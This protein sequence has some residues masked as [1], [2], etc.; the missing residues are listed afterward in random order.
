[1]VKLKNLFLALT[2]MLTFHQKALGFFCGCI[3][4]D[5]QDFRVFVAPQIAR[6]QLKIDHM[7]IYRGVMKGGSAGVEYKPF[8]NFYTGLFAEWMMGPVY[9][10]NSMSRYIHDFDTQARLG[11]N[12][13]MWNFY[14]LTFTPFFG[15]GYIQEIH[16]IRPDLVLDSLRF[17]YKNYYLPYGA[18]V[19]FSITKHFAFGFVVEK[20]ICIVER[21]DTPYVEKVEFLLNQ[22]SD[23]LFEVPFFLKFGEQ[24]KFEMS[25]IPYLK[26]EVDGKLEAT[27]PDGAA[28]GLPM[29]DY[30]YWG[31]RL[32]LGAVF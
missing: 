12:V 24:S 6:L 22:K 15:L 32:G 25:L 8:C 27:L 2:L 13:P 18:L 23:Y 5:Y 1:M 31:F 7:G 28:I 9:S 3:P 26:R 20:R 11:Y 10:P 4:K 30:R 16:H 17:R 29:Q 14:K 21:L 19:D